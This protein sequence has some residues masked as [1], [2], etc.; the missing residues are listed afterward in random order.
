MTIERLLEMKYNLKPTVDVR[1][2]GKAIVGYRAIIEEIKSY[3]GNREDAVIVLECYPG[4]RKEEIENDFLGEFPEIKEKIFIDEYG[5]TVEEVQKK[6]R[7]HITEDRVFGVYSHYNIQDFYPSEQLEAARERLAGKGLKV[8]YGF[9]ASLLTK[10]DVL[11]SIGVSRWEIQL[12]YRNEQMTNWKTN[13]PDEEGIGKFK[14]GFFFEWPMADR[15][16]HGIYPIIDYYI[17][18]VKTNQPKMITGSQYRQ[19]TAQIA[20]QPFRTVP[21]FDESVWG[22]QWMKK[23][24][25]LPEDKENYG[26]A[27]DGV[28]EENSLLL[29]FENDI[30]EIPSQVVVEEE[31][32]N[33]LGEK[34]R[35]RFGRKFPIRF[36]YLDTMD[37]GNLSLQVHPLTEYAFDKFGMPFTQDESYYILDCKEGAKVYL[38]TK[39]GITKDTLFNDLKKA[40]QTG[41]NFEAEKYV[42]EI[43][44]KK[45]DHFSIPAGTIHCSGKNTVVLEISATPYIFTFKLWDWGRVGL[46]GLPRPIHLEHGIEN[47][48]MDRNEEYINEHLFTRLEN[49][50]KLENQQIGVTSERTG[51][52]EIE[53]ID[54]I[55]HWFTDEVQLQTNESVNMLCLVEGS[56]ILVCSTNNT[57]Q[58]MEVHYGETFIVP[59]SVKE[60]TLKAKE[61]GK[62]A[63]I[64]AFVKI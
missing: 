60:Y 53:F 6:I 34:V 43:T 57:F 55:R 38:G 2:K 27:F 40:N 28:P 62:F 8:I 35:A 59:E 30:V 1:N 3:L 21:Y 5:L 41:E 46:N 44:V 56:E 32:T 48:Q 42:N 50:E 51:L 17:D 16:Q 61:K 20:K 9:G 11:I 37:G 7:D 54:S 64:Q 29:Q 39:T 47:I 18:T 12:R 26:W 24:F 14:R 31:T 58:P 22:G 13:N 19:A 45:H 10:A 25:H 4:V 23:N 15:L 63:V 52:A 33:L 36:D 49:C